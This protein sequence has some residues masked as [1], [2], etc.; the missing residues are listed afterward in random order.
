MRLHIVFNTEQP[1]K[2]PWNYQ[3]LLHGFLYGAIA[4]SRPQLGSFLHEQGFVAENHRYK[5]VV[6]SKFYPRRASTCE[7]GLILEPPIH[8]WVS[9]P[10]T[11]P[12]EALATTLLT[13]GEVFLQDSRL[14]VKRIEVEPVPELNG[15]VL[16][17]TISPVVVSTGVLSGE[18]LKKQFLSPDEKR[19]WEIVEAN[20]RRKAR[21]LGL[22]V[23]EKEAVCFKKV[24]RWRSRLVIV[25]G[26]KVKCYEGQFTMEGE[27]SLL[28]LAY[29]AGL[30][31][32]NMQGFGMFRIKNEP[33]DK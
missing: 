23:E 8:W 28:L 6:F 2:L 19:F 16:C 21:A 17:E 24:G 32:R 13:E 18:K 12:V 33:L 11:A 9:S 27:K 4:R 26:T 29:E 25:Q 14:M 15:H 20:L 3:H 1:I 31:E 30:G 10:L 22:Q 5:M 7:T